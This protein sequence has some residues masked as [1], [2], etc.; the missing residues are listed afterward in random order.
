MIDISALMTAASSATKILKDLREIDRGINE[1]EYKFQIAELFE[2][3][4]DMKMAIIEL[5]EEGG[6][7]DKKIAELTRFHADKEK[8]VVFEGYYYTDG[9][10]GKPAGQAHCSVCMLEGCL[11]L[12]SRA[13]VG[14]GYTCPRCKANIASTSFPWRSA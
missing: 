14:G 2:T 3:I 5:K 9:G 6:E 11:I 8:L 1:A 7:K 13:R 10:D 12:T 4:A